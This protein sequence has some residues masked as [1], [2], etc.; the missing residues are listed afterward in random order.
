MNTALQRCYVVVDSFYT[1]VWLL[2]WMQAPG[3][4]ADN[5]DIKREYWCTTHRF[6]GPHGEEVGHQCWEARSQTALSNETQLEL[7]HTHCIITALPV[8]AGDIQQVGLRKQNNHYLLSTCRPAEKQ[9]LSDIQQ[10]GLQ[11]TGRPAK[12]NHYLIF[13]RYLILNKLACKKAI[14]MS[15]STGRPA[16]PPPPPHTH[17]HNQTI[18]TFLKEHILNTWYGKA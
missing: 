15:H 7:C 16:T 2:H 13:N 9:S 10:V 11:N 1:V 6:V 12:N 8:P 14:I 17:T 3:A 5:S 18:M 4:L